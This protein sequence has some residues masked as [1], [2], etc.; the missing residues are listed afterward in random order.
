MSPRVAIVR[1]L[2]TPFAKSGTHF[3]RLSALDLGKMVVAKLIE[4]SGIDA[5]TVGAVE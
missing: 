4:R 3:A 5:S 1:G 2:R